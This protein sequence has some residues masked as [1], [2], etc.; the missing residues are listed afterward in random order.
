MYTEMVTKRGFTLEHFVDL[1]STNA[2]K[3]MGLYPRK[4]VLAVG[5]DADI[6]LLDPKLAH[7][8]DGSALHSVDYSPWDG[9]EVSVWP[10]VVVLRGKVMVEGGQFN[11]VLRTESSCRARFQPTSAKAWASDWKRG[12]RHGSPARTHDAA[13][14]GGHPVARRVAR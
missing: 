4:G 1:I 5:S 13:G 2:A 14:L 3:I 8:I 12:S 9:W 7:K 11:G 6:V 10:S